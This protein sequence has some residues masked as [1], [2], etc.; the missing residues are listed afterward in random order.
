MQPLVMVR[1]I[2]GAYKYHF[3]RNGRFGVKVQLASKDDSTVVFDIDLLGFIVKAS[4]VAQRFKVS[5]AVFGG[6]ALVSS[7]WVWPTVARIRGF[8]IDICG[9]AGDKK[10]RQDGKEGHKF[11]HKTHLGRQ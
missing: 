5:I 8:F 6:C 4:M 10:E 9:S 2:D 3:F 11:F 7:S 1:V